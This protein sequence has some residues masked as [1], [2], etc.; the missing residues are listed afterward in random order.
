VT[1]NC[2]DA[3]SG[4]A[5]C[6]APVL[7]SAQGTN[8]SVKGTATDNAGNSNQTT[9][10]GINIET[11]APAVT[12]T[13]NAGTYN[14]DQ[15][16]NITCGVTPSLSPITTST[17]TKI[18]GAAYSFGLGAHPYS[19]SASDQ[20]GNTGTGKTSFNVVLNF[21]GLIGLVNQFETKAGIAAEIVADIQGAQ[22][23]FAMG[24]INAGD[25]QLN[26]ASNLISA[27]S[28]KSLTTMQAA[29]LIQY[30]RALRM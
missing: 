25:N 1:F 16:V 19:A 18:N 23:S 3:I 6:P 9:I 2:S 11:T 22:A 24:I 26:A 17:C 10:G 5:S 4:I 12:Y 7:L 20:A 14:V 13:G 28:G 8:L 15:T 27:Q 29:L 30:L 21:T